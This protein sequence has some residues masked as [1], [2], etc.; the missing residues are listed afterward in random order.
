MKL[1]RAI[2]LCMSTTLL[3]GFSIPDQSLVLEEYGQAAV[4]R[5]TV[6]PVETVALATMEVL[7]ITFSRVQPLPKQRRLHSFDTAP[8]LDPVLG[9][10]SHRMW[11]KPLQAPLD[12]ERSEIYNRLPGNFRG[13]GFPDI[14]THRPVSARN[15][16]SSERPSNWT[17]MVSWRDHGQETQSREAIAYVRCMGLSPYAVARRADRYDELIN[18]VALEYDVS[19]SL[20]KAMITEESCFNKDAVSP[21]GALGLMQLMPDTAHWLKVKDPYSP[22]ENVRAGVRYIAALQTQFESLDLALAAYNAG[23]GNV[24]RYGGIPPFAET[25]AYVRKV[26]AHYRRYAAAGRLA[27]R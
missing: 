15:R 8:I 5:S 3:V 24:R 6:D 26:K 10:V 9:H 7:P 25:R 17:R 21:V 2:P 18:V 4:V 19:A 1:S 14:R 27:A 23:P 13:V 12:R 20:I 22:T 16:S 11:I